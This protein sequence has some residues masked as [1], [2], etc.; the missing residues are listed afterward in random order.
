M[1]LQVAALYQLGSLTS[2]LGTVT[3]SLLTDSSLKLLD[4]VFSGLLS[5]WLP[6]R[7]ASSQCLR[8]V[9][10]AVPS[11][12]TPLIDKSVEA[13]ENYKGSAEAVSGYSSGLA[14]LLG[15]VRVTPNGIPH[16]R[17]KVIFN[18]GEELL[19]SASQSSRLS[20]DRTKAGWLLIG[21]LSLEYSL[22]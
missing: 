8:H 10:S 17:G 21:N 7:L 14:G 13:L 12:L 9:S 15:A 20:R 16:T 11:V 22:F 5:P 19:R 3:T 1:S 4:T 6:V 18:C 2:R